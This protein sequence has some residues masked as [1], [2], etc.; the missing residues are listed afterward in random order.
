MMVSF[1][2]VGDNSERPSVSASRFFWMSSA[3]PRMV[4]QKT[5]NLQQNSRW[6]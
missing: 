4:A 5:K 6:D 2:F 1:W 3:N